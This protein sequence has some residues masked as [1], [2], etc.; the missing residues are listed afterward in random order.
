MPFARANSPP[1]A[2]GNDCRI[3]LP[4]GRWSLQGRQ[5]CLSS[6]LQVVEPRRN[7]CGLGPPT[8]VQPSQSLEAKLDS[9]PERVMRRLSCV[10]SVRHRPSSYDELRPL[11][12]VDAVS[13]SVVDP[14]LRHALAYRLSHRQDYQADQ[15]FAL[16]NRSLRSRTLRGSRSYAQPLVEHVGCFGLDHTQSVSQQ[17]YMSA[18]GSQGKTV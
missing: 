12:V 9:P 1:R 8:I 2:E 16:A 11:G 7:G 15:P 10:D 6:S 14:H 17:D 4:R 5:P 3:V 18:N 13:R